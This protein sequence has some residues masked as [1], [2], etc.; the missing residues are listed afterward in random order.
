MNTRKDAAIFDIGQGT[1]VMGKLLYQKGFTNIEGAD[2]CPS[3]VKTANESGWYK[4]SS[5][6]WFGKGVDTLPS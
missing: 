1:G 4:K 3:Y 6:M 2:A 5:V